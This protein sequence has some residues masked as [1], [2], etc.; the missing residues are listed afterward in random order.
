VHIGQRKL[1]ARVR[2]T[3]EAIH[4]SMKSE[5]AFARAR[6]D[7]MT[8]IIDDIAR[9]EEYAL[10]SDGRGVLCLVN[11]A[12]RTRHDARGRLARRHRRRRLRQPLLP[13]GHV[14]RRAV[15]PAT[16]SL[17][18]GIRKITAARLTARRSRSTRLSARPGRQRL[19]RAG[20]ELERHRHSRHLYEH[21][22]WG[23]TALF[24]DGTYR[25]NYF[26]VDR[27]AVA[28]FQTYVKASTGA[29]SLDLFQQV[30]TSS[31]RS[32]EGPST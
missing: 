16:G 17:R 32:S 15:D 19:H 20:R 3:S 23:L 30:P 11:A 2:I 14:C 1:M 26:N 8:R 21:G 9:M 7:E 25:N 18:S 22:F 24:D 5:G 10:S 31:T 13:A 27:V 29:L 4:D 6:K 12:T 28:A